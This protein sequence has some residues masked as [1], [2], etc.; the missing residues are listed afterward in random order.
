[1]FDIF[2]FYAL[3]FA[4]TLLVACA[5]TSL[6]S[7]L[8][9]FL[10]RLRKTNEVLRHPYLKQHPWERYPLSIRT[11]ILLDYFLRLCFP[12]STFW[13]F[14]QANRLLPHVTPTEV[15]SRIKWPLI[16]LWSG[17][18][19]GIFAMLL[20]WGLILLTMNP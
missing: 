1:M 9:L 18:F 13:I 3:P 19:V 4:F 10:F 16:G 20:L 15:P 2:V 7:G 8:M 14:G 11:A 17:C 6:V 12:N 5:L